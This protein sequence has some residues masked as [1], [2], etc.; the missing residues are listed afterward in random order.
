M[1]TIDEL[2]KE[3]GLLEESINELLRSFIR[4]NP[5]L[6]V[7]VEITTTELM[8]TGIPKQHQISVSVI[9]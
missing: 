1:K 3:K 8:G 7:E 9:L 6:S 5:K 2:L 4:N